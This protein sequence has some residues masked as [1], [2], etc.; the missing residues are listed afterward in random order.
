MGLE[1]LNRNEQSNNQKKI[2]KDQYF[3]LK[4]EFIFLLFVTYGISI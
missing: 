1:L 3:F 2:I 4:E